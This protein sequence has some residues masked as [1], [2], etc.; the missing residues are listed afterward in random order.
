[1]T[2][3][4]SEAAGQ[5]QL[6]GAALDHHL[7]LGPLTHR[8][9]VCVCGYLAQHG[10]FSIAVLQLHRESHTIYSAALLLDLSTIALGD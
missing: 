7:Q 2:R 4:L 6:T 10:P 8:V 9:C 5:P 1:M 3:G